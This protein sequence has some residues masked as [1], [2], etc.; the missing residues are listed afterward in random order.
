MIIM[1]RVSTL[2]YKYPSIENVF[3]EKNCF[4]RRALQDVSMEFEVKIL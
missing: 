1:N 2:F 4:P 3:C